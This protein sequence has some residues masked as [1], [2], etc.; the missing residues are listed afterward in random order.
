LDFFGSLF[1]CSEVPNS[2]INEM[3]QVRPSLTLCALNV[4]VQNY[5][6]LAWLREYLIQTRVY[7]FVYY[8]REEDD[9]IEES[10]N[11]ER[12]FLRETRKQTYFD[13]MSPVRR[14]HETIP[15]AELLEEI[16]KHFDALQDHYPFD[17]IDESSYTPMNVIY[18]SIAISQK[19]SIST[20]KMAAAWKKVASIPFKD[21]LENGSYAKAKMEELQSL[22]IYTEEEFTDLEL[23]ELVKTWM[24]TDC[25]HFCPR[26][27]EIQERPPEVLQTGFS[28]DNE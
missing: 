18:F 11:E 28:R 8:D 16:M 22:G 7:N 26:E 9:V 24:K 5:F 21:Q 4:F 3:K 17:A 23:R 27:N 10:A 15:T 1:G 20:E 6:S 13:L 19:V 2:S 14:A 12:Q 25:K